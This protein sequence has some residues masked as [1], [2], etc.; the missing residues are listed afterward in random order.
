M[1]SMLLEEKVERFQDM[2]GSTVRV[3]VSEFARSKA[4]RE[5]LP[6]AGCFEVIDRGG[7]VGYMLAP[8]C[9]TALNDHITALEQQLEQAQVAAMFTA[10][11]DYS[12]PQT[13]EQLQ[14]S[15]RK[16]F[17]ERADA[18]MELVDAG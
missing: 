13:G 10:R 17:D 18:L 11:Q 15:V 2:V 9:A 8:D 6:E 16:A 3:G 5:R 12:A 4:W 7:V 1:S 14:A